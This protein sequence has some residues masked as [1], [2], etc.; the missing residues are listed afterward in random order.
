MYV[1]LITLLNNLFLIFSNVGV[2]RL[3][4]RKP[5]AFLYALSFT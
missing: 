1:F 3:T 4:I 2:F 5:H